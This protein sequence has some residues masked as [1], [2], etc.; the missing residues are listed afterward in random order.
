MVKIWDM[1]AGKLL[2]SFAV[3]AA[4]VVALEFNPAEFL[5]A[6]VSTDKKL[7]LYDL[8]NFELVSES[9]PMPSMPCALE[10]HP[11]GH[12]RLKPYRVEIESDSPPAGNAAP[13]EFPYLKP[14]PASSRADLNATP[15]FDLRDVT[16][17]HTPPSIA[18][19]QP[20]PSV[21][22]V[23]AAASQPEDHV[24]PPRQSRQGTPSTLGADSTRPASRTYLRKTKSI[25]S[26]KED[27]PSSSTPPVHTPPTAS[28]PTASSSIL[29][30]PEDLYSQPPLSSKKP[31]HF[32]GS[33]GDRPLNLDVSNFIQEPRQKGV[34][35]PLSPTESGLPVASTDEE[36]IESL[37][38]RHISMVSIFSN[39]LQ[40]IKAI[41]AGWDE[42]DI[43]A[44]METLAACRD[45][46][47]WIDVFRVI[48]LKPK[49][50]TLEIAAI[51][52]PLL[53]ELLFEVYE[54]YITTACTTVRLL[55]KSFA[56]VIISAVINS[57]NITPGLDFAREERLERCRTCLA[58]FHDISMTLQELKRAP[59]RVGMAVRETLNELQIF[60]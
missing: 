9:Q 30:A 51:L 46:A 38:F 57:A 19:V 18:N 15:T 27:R 6:T 40:S 29:Q 1:T 49:L 32:L 60:G 11:D 45:P 3:P 16:P 4:K 31:T 2:T 13:Q 36:I 5:M 7:R 50:L 55:C 24:V 48:N 33:S 14:S 28:T 23:R 8:Q 41:R 35:L 37:Q 42:G 58:K 26:F 25:S 17:V 43:K 21:D 44:S 56:Q 54:D 39:R 10:F 52:L 59:G 53:N 20:S 34:S 22:P 47:V 12:E